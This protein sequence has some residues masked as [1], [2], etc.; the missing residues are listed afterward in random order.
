M[1]P[2]AWT[3]F[4]FPG[5]DKENYELSFKKYPFAITKNHIVTIDGTKY[6]VA[7]IVHELDYPSEENYRKIYLVRIDE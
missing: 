4:C 7:E 5:L 2:I 3:I 6:R 1:K